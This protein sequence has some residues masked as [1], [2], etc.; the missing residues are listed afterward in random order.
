MEVCEK[1]VFI[2]KIYEQKFTLSIQKYTK[3][4]VYSNLDRNK[5]ANIDIFGKN[6]KI[7]K[8]MNRSKRNMKSA[9]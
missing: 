6:E 5:N 4:V 2:W 7:L 9:W 1:N 8:K 3:Y